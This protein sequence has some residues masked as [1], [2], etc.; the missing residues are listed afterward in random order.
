MLYSHNLV[1]V[2]IW[3]LGFALIAYAAFKDVTISLWCFAL[4]VFHDAEDPAGGF[5]GADRDDQQRQ[6]LQG[7]RNV[8]RGKVR[9]FFHDLC[10]RA[11]DAAESEMAGRAVRLLRHTRCGAIATAIV[12][13]T[14][15]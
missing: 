9:G 12:R 6:T 4:I 2:A 8:V 5:D 14:Q 10:R 11:H 15:V 3:A 1:P 7:E 13:R